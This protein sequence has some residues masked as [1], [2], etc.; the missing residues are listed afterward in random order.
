GDD[1]L[2]S[3][4]AEK[5]PELVRRG[6][7]PPEHLL[8][9]GRLPLWLELDPSVNGDTLTSQ[10]QSQIARQ[11]GEYEAYHQ[12]NASGGEKPLEDWAKVVLVPGVGVITAFGDKKSAV[13]ANLCYPATLESL[14]NAESIGGFQF[15]PEKDVFEFEHWPLERRKVDE[16]I[17]K[18]RA[19]KLLFRQVAVII[20]GGSG[21][22]LA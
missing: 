20:G 6:M 8:R 14:I 17:E 15:V 7:A 13:T 2:G 16:T 11:R 4:S 10:V 18:E 5:A 3:L 22:G 9:A 21:I 12:R 1:S 19:T